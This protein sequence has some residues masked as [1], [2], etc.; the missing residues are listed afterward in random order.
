MSDTPRTDAAEY[1]ALDEPEEKL[2]LVDAG[3]AR[4]LERELTA[5]QA[6]IARLKAG[7]CARDQRTTQFCGEAVKLQEENAKLQER[8]ARLEKAG[9][10]LDRAASKLAVTEISDIHDPDL[11]IPV[12]SVGEDYE[13]THYSP[14]TAGEYVA[15]NTAIKSWRTAKDT[16]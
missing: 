1:F 14:P 16:Q 3:F 12:D 7:G 13:I 4:Q 11:M 8:I 10:Y 2:D 15:L 6:E 5:A 9:N